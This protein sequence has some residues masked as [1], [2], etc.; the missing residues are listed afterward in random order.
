MTDKAKE[1]RRFVVTAEAHD[2]V[3]T[4]AKNPRDAAIQALNGADFVDANV[5]EVFEIGRGKR[6]VR[7]STAVPAGK[8]KA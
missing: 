8:D 7:Q 6:Y 3:T 5:V 1:E 4:P 2:S